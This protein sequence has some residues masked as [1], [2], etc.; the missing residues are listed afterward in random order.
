MNLPTIRR[1]YLEAPC[2]TSWPETPK[3]TVLVK[4][5]AGNHQPTREE[6]HVLAHTTALGATVCSKWGLYLLQRQYS[7]IRNVHD[8]QVYAHVSFP[9]LRGFPPTLPK[10]SQVMTRPSRLESRS[11]ARNHLTFKC[12]LIPVQEEGYNTL[13][14][15][16]VGACCATG[17]G[18]VTDG[19]RA[20]WRG[21]G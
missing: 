18:G 2:R 21:G 17:G 8:V 1:I 3:A 19:G 13:P 14:G 7:K 15:A 6:T 16:G 20:S 12:Q 11:R 5:L 4:R 9:S 10:I